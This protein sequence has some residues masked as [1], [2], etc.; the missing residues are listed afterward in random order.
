MDC[1]IRTVWIAFGSDHHADAQ[2]GAR[3][4]LGKTTAGLSDEHSS[5][6]RR[7]ARDHGAIAKPAA[8]RT[9][10]LL[11]PERLVGPA[12]TVRRK[13]IEQSRRVIP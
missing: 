5:R 13:H 11:I 8:R 7:T 4:G 12:L 1:K 2:V 3:P 6:K 9:S 10:Q